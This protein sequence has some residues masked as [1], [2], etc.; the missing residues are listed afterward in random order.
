MLSINDSAPEI[1]RNTTTSCTTRHLSDDGLDGLSRA[2]LP[3]GETSLSCQETEGSLLDEDAMSSTFSIPE[4][5]KSLLGQ[6]NAATELNSS[7]QAMKLKHDSLE[8]KVNEIQ[9]SI[10]EVLVLLK[11]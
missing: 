1:E 6:K 4:D 2:L 9:S 5:A 3:E 11:K 10:S 7:F 8:T